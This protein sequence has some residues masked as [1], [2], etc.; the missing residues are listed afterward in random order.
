[1]LKDPRNFLWIAPLVVLL[2][3]PLWKPLAADILTPARKE[4]GMPAPSLANTDTLSSSEMSG[5]EFEQIKN[6]T[7]DWH[8][9]AS[10]LYKTGRDSDL[11][12]EDVKGLFFGAA[13]SDEETRI[14]SQKA[15]YNEDT[16]QITLQGEVVI[17][18]SKGYEM[19]TDALEYFAAEKKIRTTSPVNIQG[20]N[21][22]VSGNEL[23][24][25]TVTG[26]YR[27]EGNVVCRVW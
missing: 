9:T 24:Y 10:R 14:R 17:Q 8:L 22:A 26:N 18:N 12:L 23:L 7:K 4:K 2:T 11:L 3:M 1:M 21:I 13:G 27:L 15:R 19:Q 5:V 16:K 25:D 20:S 6:G